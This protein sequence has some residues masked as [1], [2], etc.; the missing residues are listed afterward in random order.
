L[1]K[2]IKLEEAKAKLRHPIKQIVSDMTDDEL[3]EMLKREYLRRLT[4]YKLADEL[5]RKKYGMTF[6]EFEQENLVA[7][8]D[9]TL[10][11]LH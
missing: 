2:Q 11:M 4:R 8:V 9:I 1:E 10:T 7:K 5:F 3:Q 6:E